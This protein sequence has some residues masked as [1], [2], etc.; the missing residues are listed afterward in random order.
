[1]KMSDIDDLHPPKGPAI[2]DKKETT[3]DRAEGPSPRAKRT[4][5]LIEM[6]SKIC[7]VNEMLHIMESLGVIVKLDIDIHTKLLEAHV[8]LSTL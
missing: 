2:V 1:M 3:K 5:A 6:Q 4:T 8:D 7:D